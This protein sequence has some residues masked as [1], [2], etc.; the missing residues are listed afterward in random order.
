VIFVH[1]NTAD[2]GDWYPAREDFLA[3]GWSEQELWALSYNGLGANV[4]S[5][6]ACDNPQPV[7]ADSPVLAGAENLDYPLADHN[8]LRLREGPHPES[9]ARSCRP[10]APPPRVAGRRRSASRSCSCGGSAPDPGEAHPQIARPRPLGEL[11][12]ACD[13][14][15]P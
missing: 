2:H 5:T 1:G 9:A 15:P 14:V 11:K 3:A 8:E 6:E 10:P 13:S 4:S 12:R 7:Y